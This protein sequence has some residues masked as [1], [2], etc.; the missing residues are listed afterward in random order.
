MKKNYIESTSGS[1]SVKV[2]EILER[3]ILNGTYSAG[4]QLVESKI[5]SELGVSRT[6]VREALKQL[7]LEGLAMSMPNRGVV[8]K[9][10]S[11]SDIDDMYNIRQIRYHQ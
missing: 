9:A 8:V 6:P 1:L 3:D 11:Q 7:E 5:S 2:F 4:D 10:I